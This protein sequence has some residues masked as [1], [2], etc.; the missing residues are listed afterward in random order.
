MRNYLFIA[1]V[2][3]ALLGALL[4]LFSTINQPD[5]GPSPAKTPQ[6]E[7]KTF[8]LEPGLA[9]QLVASEP[10][11]QDPVFIQF[12]EFGRLWVVEMRGFMPDI[13]GLGESEPVGRINILEDTDGDGT[14]DISTIY[15]DSLIMPRALAV[16]GDGALVVENMALWWTKDLDGDGKADTKVMVDPDY[17]G[18]HLPEHSA[19]GLLRGMDNWHYNSRSRFRY[20][21]VDPEWIRDTTELRG[22]WGISQDNF[23]RLVYNYNWSQLHADLVPP[24]Y[25]S[26]NPYHTPTTG[27]D[28]GLSVDRRIYPIRPNPAINRGYIPGILDE[29]GRLQEFTA[30]CAPFYYR[31]TALP[32]SYYGNVFVCEPSG[33]LIKRNV[34][35]EDG[36]VLLAEDPNPGRE[37]LASTDERF[38]PVNLASGPDGAL[39]IADMYRG[40]VQ[41]GAY[42]TPYLREQTLSRNLLLPVNRGRIWRIVPEGL[43]PQ[44]IPKLATYALDELVNT[45]FHINGWHRDIAQR[46][47]VERNDPQSIPMLWKAIHKKEGNWGK[48]HALWTLEALGGLEPGRLTNLLLYPDP[49]VSATALRLLEP[50]AQKNLEL[51]PIILS[52]ITKTSL[53]SLNPFVL[54]LA[55]SAPILLPISSLDILGKIIT[56]HGDSPLIRDA[57]LSGLEDQQFAFLQFLLR[58]PEWDASNPEKEVVL[59]MLT[60]A[61]ITKGD[62]KEVE[63]LLVFLEQHPPAQNWKYKPILTALTIGGGNR[64]EPIPLT[65]APEITKTVGSNSLS[66]HQYT[67]LA[68]LFTWPGNE[69][70]KELLAQSVKLT[71]V[72]QKLFALG[73]QHYLSTCSGCHGNAGEG[74]NRMGP[75]LAGSEW[76]TG[77]QKQ[78]SLIV[79]HGMEGPLEVKGKTYDTPDILP[80][81]PAHTSLDDGTLSAILTYIRNE[82]GNNA[83]AID[84]RFIATTRNVTQG[85]VIPW[86]A[87]ELKTYIQSEQEKSQ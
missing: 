61:I 31:G 65:Q 67:A 32:E 4:V 41:H 51:E 22:Q 52:R 7:L 74:V 87:E 36:I 13:E 19:N 49:Y 18:N 48:I 14:M 26:Q 20:K 5:L 84:R 70:K 62:S 78:L 60:G 80:V 42:I 59:E 15:L 86:G 25:L 2:G 82:W 73:R 28:H 77:D 79:L 55:L 85:R 8:Q 44:L 53:S 46:L 66:P 57:V 34:V 50:S 56:L 16:V 72:E 58:H 81:M 27:I 11:V 1:L 40:L 63:Q 83:G 21:R 64:L 29:E 38:R 10:L 39:Y 37:F 9:I 71:A 68:N 75:P 47:L 23:G 17:A 54:Q 76:V 12:D 33:N 43:E 6:D 3:I 45:L 35:T 30:A 69:K 24:N